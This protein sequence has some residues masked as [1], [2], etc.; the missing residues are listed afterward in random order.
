M[1]FESRGIEYS[2]QITQNVKRK[3]R[4]CFREIF[5]NDEALLLCWGSVSRGEMAPYS[6]LD[7]ILLLNQ[8]TKKSKIA[9]FINELRKN[10]E[11]RIDLLEAY[12]LKTLEKIGNIDGTDRQAVLLAVPLCG[13]KAIEQEFL[14]LQN[15]FYAQKERNLAEVVHTWINLLTVGK[16]LK[17]SKEVNIKFSH[18]LLRQA[19]YIYFHI[20]SSYIRKIKPNS[21]IGVI[22]E[23]INTCLTNKK[24]RNSY[25]AALDYLIMIRNELHI[26]KSNEVYLL[27]KSAIQAISKKCKVTQSQLR[28]KIQSSKQV[29]LALE[30]KITDDLANRFGEFY[31]RP[32]QIEAFSNLLNMSKKITSTDSRMILLSDNIILLIL[33]SHRCTDAH[34]LEE[35]RKKFIENWYI[36]YGIANNSSAK[37]GTLHKL[38]SLPTGT[39]RRIVS[40]YSGFAWRNVRLYVAKKASVDKKTLRY[41]IAN[42]KS[43][44]MDVNA[45]NVGLIKLSNKHD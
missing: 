2:K 17:V 36:M 26:L 29:I 22:T 9:L 45:A 13:S 27:N 15:R 24:E 19:T 44:P 7:L 38:V 8:N 12:D 39:P 37:S 10:F 18:G 3:C 35:L 33:L 25:M 4:V 40:L 28:K 14:L 31:T 30:N 16:N 5:S 42:K 21:T 11:N 20:A 34:I 32:D 6:D 43:R 23:P 41:I 1:Q